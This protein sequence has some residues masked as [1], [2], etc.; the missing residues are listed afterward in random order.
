MT[1]KQ[2]QQFN[3]IR[4][5][6]EKHVPKLAEFIECDLPIFKYSEN[7]YEDKVEDKYL[8]RQKVVKESIKRQIIELFGEEAKKFRLNLD[9][10]LRVNIVDH[11]GILNHPILT[12]SHIIS[13]AWQLFDRQSDILSLNTAL[14][15]FNSVF[16]KRGLGYR[17]KT[18][19][20]VSKSKC[21]QLVYYAPPVNFET[22]P[23]EIKQIL[24]S[25]DRPISQRAWQQASRINY[26]LWPL[27]FE[28]A[29][30][31]K[32]PR[33]ITLNQDK[34]VKDLLIHL[35]KKKDNF[36]YE[37]IFNPQLRER[38]YQVFLNSTGAWFENQNKGSFLFWKINEKN[39]GVNLVLK[40]G[41]LVSVKEKYPYQLELEEG[42]VIEALEKDEIYAGMVLLFGAL[43]FYAGVVP[44]AG[45]GSVNYLNVMKDKWLKLLRDQYPEEYHSIKQMNINKLIG[46]PVLAY[47]RDKE[48]KLQQAYALDIIMK[49]GLKREYLEKVLS[50]P[51]NELLKPALIDVYNSY[52]PA[53]VREEISITTNDVVNEQFAWIK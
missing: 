38:C 10:P 42:A 46:G 20:F 23:D 39:E 53:E 25:A 3:I 49:G 35:I 4:R 48:N 14:Y 22:F 19:S 44:L 45:Y 21:H 31:D 2:L 27:L 6:I 28:P 32:L 47:Y 5:G 24:Q 8:V 30:R 34:V 15:P 51:F 36:I 40:D 17:G 9:G 43:V 26:K 13:S 33:L 7:L 41:R 50:M 37:V 29:L 18:L 11:N 52:I 12:G 1:V 16:Y